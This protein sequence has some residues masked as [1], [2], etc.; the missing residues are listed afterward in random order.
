MGP[1][2]LIGA[3][4]GALGSLAMGKSPFTGALLG[5][6]TGG[7]FGG[8]GGFGSGFGLGEGGLLSG[9]QGVAPEAVSL[10][11]GGYANLG[12]NAFGNVG[13]AATGG[14]DFGVNGINSTL[15]G[16]NLP[17]GGQGIQ[18]DK[19]YPTAN[20]TDE[21]LSFA[22]KGLSS[23]DQM[24]ANKF[25][26]ETNPLALDPRRLAV[27]TPLSFG[28]KLSDVGSNIFSYGKE[29]PMSVLSGAN[30]ISNMSA[31]ADAQSQQ[32]L[33]DAIAK[34]QV[35]IK[36]GDSTMTQSYSMP[37]VNASGADYGVSPESI[38]AGKIA[39]LSNK[40]FARIP[41]TDKRKIGNFYTSLIG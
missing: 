14:I 26:T 40:A 38:A 9:F 37:Q 20:F 10:G 41:E 15:G 8:A 19:F 22:D 6:V 23:A 11:T 35:P 7:A 13:G 1:P 29:N 33:N 4:V 39:Q 34:G 28:E 12:A 31:N 2:M 25:S 30:T 5:G 17:L 16:T 27:N 32:R 21:G 18:L 36:Q 24:F 3:G